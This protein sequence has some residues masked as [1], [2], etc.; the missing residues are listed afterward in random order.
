MLCV[1]GQTRLIRIPEYLSVLSK[2][3]GFNDVE[4]R[5][6][7]PVSSGVRGSPGSRPDALDRH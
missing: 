7:S 6:A 3:G 4:Q 5:G 2:E 1:D